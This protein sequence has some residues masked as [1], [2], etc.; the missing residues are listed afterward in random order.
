MKTSVI[1]VVASTLVRLRKEAMYEKHGWLAKF[2]IDYGSKTSSI[3]ARFLLDESGHRFIAK[4]YKIL[5]KRTVD[6]DGLSYYSKE[7][8]TGKLNKLE[9][10]LD[11]LNSPEGKENNPNISGLSWRKALNSIF[12][13]KT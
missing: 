2:Y 12:R 1:S 13:S 6:S 11:I 8:E 5:L 9:I 7:L 4:A 3:P 10:I